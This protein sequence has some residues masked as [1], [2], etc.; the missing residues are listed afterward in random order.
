MMKVNTFSLYLHFNFDT[1]RI[2]NKIPSK[3][4]RW[5]GPTRFLKIIRVSILLVG[6]KKRTG[7]EFQKKKGGLEKQELVILQLFKILETNPVT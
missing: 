6:G 5:R 3:A 2:Q 1:R 4:S 7:K